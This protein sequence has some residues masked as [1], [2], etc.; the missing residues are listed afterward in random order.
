[1]LRQCAGAKRSS[2]I[3]SFLG[4]FEV[5]VCHL[6]VAQHDF[7]RGNAPMTLETNKA[8]VRRWLK[9]GER[10]FTGDFSEYFTP[11]YLGHLSGQPPQTLDDLVRLERG[12]AASFSE[13]SYEVADLFGVRDKVV[14]RVATRATHTG[15]FQGAE[16]TGRRITITGIVIYRFVG[17]RIAESW[18]ELDF[19]GLLRQLRRN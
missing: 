16:A 7:P 3:P 19:L 13:I 12:F 10:G 14:L 17:A 9:M 2:S 6:A 15:T 11:D 4:L 1:V 18:G 8:L 5:D